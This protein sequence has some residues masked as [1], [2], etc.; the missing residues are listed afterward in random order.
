MDAERFRKVKTP[1]TQ[2]DVA[3]T[4]FVREDDQLHRSGRDVVVDTFPESL[5]SWPSKAC[6]LWHFTSSILKG[7]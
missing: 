4:F 6:S 7:I 5:A 3:L 2:L 1:I